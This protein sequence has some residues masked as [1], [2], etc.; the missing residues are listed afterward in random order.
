MGTDMPCCPE[1]QPFL[2]S[3]NAKTACAYRFQPAA[4]LDGSVAVSVSLYDTEKGHIRGDQPR[5]CP[6]VGVQGRKVNEGGSPEHSFGAIIEAFESLPPDL[7]ATISAP[8]PPRTAMPK[9]TQSGS[10]A[11]VKTSSESSGTPFDRL[12]GSY[13]MP[14]RRR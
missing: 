5:Y 11:A 2:D 8:S 7:R 10:T 12:R 13:R 4:Y 9:Q 3:R 6:V 1:F 14:G